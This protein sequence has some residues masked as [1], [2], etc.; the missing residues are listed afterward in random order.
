MQVEFENGIVKIDIAAL[1]EDQ[2]VAREVAKHAVCDE[3]LLTAFAQLATDGWVEWEDESHPWHFYTTGKGER[4][5]KLRQIIATQADAVAA[6]LINDLIKERND[7]CDRNGKLKAEI[8]QLQ[9]K[10]REMERREFDLAPAFP[11][12]EYELRLNPG[13]R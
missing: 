5:E 10:I 6:K 4:F 3:A 12:K 11:R 2:A 13:D 9:G 8:Y 7:L 1:A